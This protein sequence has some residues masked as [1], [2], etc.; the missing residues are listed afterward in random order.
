[1]LMGD[2]LFLFYFYFD[3]FVVDIIVLK[4]Q[5]LAHRITLFLFYFFDRRL[6]KGERTRKI[7]I[8]SINYA[9]ISTLNNDQQKYFNRF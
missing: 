9:F 6:L 5:A 7:H 3:N 4:R 8:I 1:M 2:F